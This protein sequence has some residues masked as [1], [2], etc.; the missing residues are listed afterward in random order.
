MV[1]QAQRVTARP[2]RIG[3]VVIAILIAALVALPLL[4]S[5]ALAADASQVQMHRL[6]NP[7]SGEHFYT[8]KKAES[9]YLASLGWKYEGVGWVAPASSNTPVYRLY[10]SR[11]GEHHY[12]T[13]E[14]ERDALVTASWTDEGI[15]WYSDDA[16]GVVLYREYNPN[17]FAC[18]HN[19]TTNKKEHDILIGMGW[20]DE[21]YAWYGVDVKPEPADDFEASQQIRDDVLDFVDKTEKAAG[22]GSTPEEKVDILLSNM[23]KVDEHLNALMESGEIDNYEPQGSSFLITLPEGQMI[24]TVGPEIVEHQGEAAQMLGDELVA[25]EQPL[26]DELVAEEQPLEGELLAEEQPLAEAEPVADALPLEAEE[27]A[28]DVASDSLVPE[29]QESGDQLAA[30]AE[31]ISDDIDQ[32]PLMLSQGITKTTYGRYLYNG[33]AYRVYDIDSIRWWKDARDYCEKVGGHLATIGDAQEDAALYEILKDA[34]YRGGFFG[35]FREDRGAAWQWVDGTPFSYTNWASGEPS[36]GNENY[37]MYYWKFS[38]GK[39]NNGTGDVYSCS[40]L[41]EWDDPNDF[42]FDGEPI[43]IATIEPFKSQ[44]S[45]DTFTNAAKELAANTPAATY[46]KSIENAQVT[47]SWLYT[48]ISLYNVIIWNGHGSHADDVH[49]VL[50]LNERTSTQKD[51]AYR[52]M[53]KN[54]EV[55]WTDYCYAVTPKLIKKYY[56]PTQTGRNL[57]YIACCASTFDVNN[58]GSSGSLME[59]FRNDGE[60]ADT[61]LG[62]DYVV[63]AGYNNALSKVFWE[64]LAAGKSVRDARAEAQKQEGEYDEKMD[65]FILYKYVTDFTFYTGKTS[66]DRHNAEPATLQY[67]GDGDLVMF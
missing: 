27:P 54:G 8:A 26:E 59:A 21:G 11:A 67:Y 23:K 48:N 3:S 16:K 62:Y 58:E 29:E 43:K 30:A 20:H 52:D 64:Q 22:E 57:T 33:H 40:F 5:A 19:Y 10:N 2:I 15:G 42:V 18:N 61:F 28:E 24:V 1:A 46:A 17:A 9:D 35:L 65:W 25:E 49:S 13:N 66:L 50:L 37:G 41:C 39:W 4:P 34:G 38:S 56:H 53:I 60:G 12:T 51:I 6:Y 44:F 14:K 31:T 7:N 36:G 63:D 55:I 47:V 45:T 32:D